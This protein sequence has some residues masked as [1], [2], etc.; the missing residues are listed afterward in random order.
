MENQ[1]ENIELINSYLNK[2]LSRKGI[3]D[4]EKRL[5]SDN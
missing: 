5:K 1:I 3:E 2:D 4:F